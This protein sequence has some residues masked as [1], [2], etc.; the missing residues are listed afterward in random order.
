MRKSILILMIVLLSS[1]NH[2][3][4]TPMYVVNLP[5]VV[6]IGHRVPHFNMSGAVLPYRDNV[7]LNQF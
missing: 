3:E 5:E 4:S 7:K 1:C 6:I 2:K